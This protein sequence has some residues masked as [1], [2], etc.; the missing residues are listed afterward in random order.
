MAPEK[1]PDENRDVKASENRIKEEAAKKPRKGKKQKTVKAPCP[2]ARLHDDLENAPSPTS[3][4]ARCL[5]SGIYRRHLM[6]KTT[7]GSFSLSTR[8][9]LSRTEVSSPRNEKRPCTWQG[10][11]LMFSVLNRVVDGQ[12]SRPTNLA[13]SHPEPP[14]PLQCRPRSKPAG[15]C[16]CQRRGALQPGTIIELVTLVLTGGQ[17]TSIMR[18]PATLGANTRGGST[19]MSVRASTRNRRRAVAVSRAETL[20][21]DLYWVQVTL[22]PAQRQPLPL[23][24]KRVPWL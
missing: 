12:E 21:R 7:R 16:G 22:P 3:F 18:C 4:S 13:S 19:D 8:R 15:N 2:G 11:V 14:H 17:R 5:C 24:L 10:V 6:T 1:T 20:T 23:T 9:P